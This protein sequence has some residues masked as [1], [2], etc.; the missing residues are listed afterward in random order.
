[1]D[2][3]VRVLVVEDIESFRE[4]CIANLERENYR[5]DGASNLQEAKAAIDRSAY[6]VAIV[7]IMLAGESDWSN[8]DGVRVLEYIRELAEGTQPIVL[9]KQSELQ[10]VRDFLKKYGAFD[11]LNKEELEHTGISLLFDMLKQAVKASPL[12]APP[13]WESFSP[14]LAWGTSED[15]FVYQ[16]L[17]VLEF[18]GGFENLSRSLLTVAGDLRPLLVPRNASRA[19]VYDQALGA[20]RG[21]YWSKGQGIAIELLLFGAPMPDSR[22]LQLPGLTG[23]HVLYNREK[24]GLLVVILDLPDAGRE[25]FMEPRAGATKVG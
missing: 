1:M 12:T 11:Y 17:R 10:L 19:I 18:K 25:A 14:S 24:A 9:S 13:A 7:D 2:K 5:A 8:R 21:K 3:R 23:R 4:S 16:C 20:F 15:D 22:I 6:H